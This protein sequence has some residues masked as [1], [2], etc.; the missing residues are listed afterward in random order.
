MALC[1]VTG[2]VYL[3]NGQLARSRTIVFRR[4][5]R[6]ITAE[7]LGTVL[8][9]DVVAQTS[10][11][12]QITVSLLTGYYV[13]HAEGQYAARIA[14]P[15]A[16]DAD[17]SDIVTQGEVPAV[18]P[19]WLSD[20]QD[21]IEDLNARVTALEGGSSGNVVM[22]TPPTA[23][24][25]TVT[26]GD[27]TTLTMGT[28]SNATSVV[29]VLM[30][31]GIDRTGEIVDGVWSPGVEGAATWTVTASGAGG[32]IVTMV[33]IT[34]EAI[35]PEQTVK[36]VA[37]LWIDA[38]TPFSGSDSEVTGVT[39]EG[40][41]GYALT[42]TGT[43]S[44][45]LITHTSDGFVFNTGRYLTVTGINPDV[46]DGAILLVDVTFNDTSGTGQALAFQ[47]TVLRR[48]SGTLQYTTGE[49]TSPAAQN[50]GTVTPPQRVQMAMHLDRIGENVRYWDV[51]GA[52]FANRAT[53]FANPITKNQINLGQGM[54]G[55]IHKVAIIAHPSGG[56]LP[57]TLEDALADFLTGA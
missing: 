50:A 53:T 24:P 21:Q 16:P 55:I 31:G 42:V 46:G 47:G 27:N 36:D 22:L 37:L 7:Y 1:N 18:P 45:N 43:G 13:A 5:N 44:P 35:A 39:A 9:D 14:V 8:P 54:S 10:T 57:M 34:V 6:N 41:G 48:A 2:T 49:W 32:P 40:S 29:G 30:Q 20:I 12:G 28:Y 38:A 51:G 26:V 25:E 33:N 23:T 11:S 56:A 52:A 15:D 17:F 19:A 4:V 3:P